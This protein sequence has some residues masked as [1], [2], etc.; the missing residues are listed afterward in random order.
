MTL[1]KNE[2]KELRVSVIHWAQL[3]GIT[4]NSNQIYPA[5]KIPNYFFFTKCRL[6]LICLFVYYFHLVLSL[7]PKVIPLYK[8]L[9][10][11]TVVPATQPIM[12][13]EVKIDHSLNLDKSIREKSIQSFI[14]QKFCRL[15]SGHH[16]K[17]RISAK[18]KIFW[19]F[20]ICHLTKDLIKMKIQNRKPHL[21]GVV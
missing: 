1:K 17:C 6:K 2:C 4:D 21:V 11:L 18:K 8:S 5:W 20:Y 3:N 14:D 19:L 15:N 9:C 10:L 13:I 12:S 16:F 7:C